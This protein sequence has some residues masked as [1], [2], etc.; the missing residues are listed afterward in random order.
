[1]LVNSH[2]KRFVELK[3]GSHIIMFETVQRFL[4]E[5]R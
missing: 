2:G 4:G 3:E 5:Q 1:V